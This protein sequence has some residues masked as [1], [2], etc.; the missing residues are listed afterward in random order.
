M[1][2]SAGLRKVERRHVILVDFW[3]WKDPNDV[4]QAVHYMRI[5][6]GSRPH[7]SSLSEFLAKKT[8]SL[9]PPDNQKRLSTTLLAQ[10]EPQ[11]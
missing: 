6:G 1:S 5:E 4:S 9:L 10:D 8:K 2:K 3:L 11:N 7:K